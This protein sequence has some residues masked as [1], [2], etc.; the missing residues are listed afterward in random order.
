MSQ[1]PSHNAFTDLVR[2]FSHDMRAPLGTI[3]STSDMMAE[4]LYE[5]LTPKQAR[6]ND[7]IRR[8][9]HRVLAMLDDFATYIKADAGQLTLSPKPFHPRTSLTEWCHVVQ[10]TAEGKGLVLHQ[11][12]H[13]SVPQT[14]RGDAAAVS[15]AFLPLLWNAVIFTVQGDIWVDSLWTEDQCWSL[16]V[17]DSGKG[18]DEANIP[19]LFKP[20]WRGVERPLVMTG[21]A[22]L[23]L[24]VSQAVAKGLN[25]HVTLEQTSSTGSTFHLQIPLSPAPD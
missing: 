1:D 21:G 4:G 10:A 8:N 11:T 2:Q 22:G 14:L 18:I 9:G 15:K 16:K 5:A 17:R 13:D 20:F 24:A 3:I 6:A 12:T 23:G 19:H 25:G 7:R